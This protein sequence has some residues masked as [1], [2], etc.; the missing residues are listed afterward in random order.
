MREAAS[1]GFWVA[2]MAPYGYRKVKVLDGPRRGPPWNR[3]PKRPASSSASS[4]L[5]ESRKGMLKIVR[6]LNDEGIASPR[7]KALE[8]AHRSQHPQK[9]GLFGHPGLGQHAK[10]NA[11]PVRV[12]K[13]F[14]ALVTK[15]QFDG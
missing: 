4:D 8:Q 13:A 11:D 10:D 2:P 7:G 12:E 1:R 5:A 9:R 14:P 6:I 15:A 3:T